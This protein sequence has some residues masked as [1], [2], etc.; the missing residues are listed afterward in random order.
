[1]KVLLVYPEIPDT[2][3]SFKYA[4]RFLGKKAG[5]PPLGLLTVAAMLPSQWGKRLVDMNVEPLREEDLRWAD[6]AFVSGMVVQRE[7]AR[8]VISR[9]KERGLEII[10]GGPLFTI[11]HEKFAGVDHF[12][13]DEA[14]ATLPRFLADWAIG[15]TRRVYRA[16]NFP[17]LSTSPVPL[18][19]LAHLGRY[20]SM[21]VQFSRGCPYDCDF[22]NVTT[23]FGRLPRTKDPDQIVRELDVLYS[24]GWREPVFF[25][26]DNLI[27]NKKALRGLLPALISWR[28]G[29][30]GMPFNTQVS[31]DLADYP[32]LMAA[33]VEAGFDTVFVG[34]ETPEEESLRECAKQQNVGRDMVGDVERMQR[35]GLRVQ[36]GF[37]V[38]FDH[39]KPPGVFKTLA[40]FIQQSGIPTAMVGLLQ[41]PPG[42]SLYERLRKEG[43]LC[44]ALTGDNV[45]GD[46]NI[47]PRM[48]LE[49]LKQGYADLLET[50][51]SPEQYYQRVRT[52]LERYELPKVQVPL[53]F[54]RVRA[55][56][57][58]VACLGILGKERGE[59]WKL[60]AWTLVHRP[61]AFSLAVTLA[62][63]GYHFRK[64][65]ELHVH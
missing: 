1:M 5:S 16:D 53:S 58:S 35:A 59:Y 39:D 6:A 8:S 33:M 17:E 51:Y 46:T 45:N 26:D 28:Q 57:R 2:F 18:F 13:L 9:C 52:L 63:Y 36:G 3:W 41:A 37:I 22:C 30:K 55:F 25:V 23:L 4:L 34:I 56:F 65:W 21:S 54:G 7:S 29:K 19:S 61:R 60:L 48:G 49:V 24:L 20:A 12:V 43:R 42:T 50:L 10:G 47:I 27:G 14:E 32:E 11:E 31:L 40:E 64:V 15:E 44:G 38:G 62:I